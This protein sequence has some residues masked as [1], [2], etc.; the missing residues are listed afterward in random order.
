MPE[1]GMDTSTRKGRPRHARTSVTPWRICREAAAWAAPAA[2]VP[3]VSRP[4][5]S[6]PL[7]GRS[8][9]P[10]ER[11]EAARRDLHPGVAGEGASTGVP[12]FVA[13]AVDAL[14]VNVLGEA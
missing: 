12:V 4:S 7:Q 5:S 8:I 14:R 1:M 11:D 2:S 3:S 6:G 9:G 10:P 13:A